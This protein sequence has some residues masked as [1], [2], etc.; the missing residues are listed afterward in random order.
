MAQPL[1]ARPRGLLLS[2]HVVDEL[3]VVHQLAQ[4]GDGGEQP[5]GPPRHDGLQLLAGQEVLVQLLLQGRQLDTHH[6]H[7]RREHREG[8]GRQ[9][10]QSRNRWLMGQTRGIPLA[11][12]S[13]KGTHLQRLGR[14]VL[15]EQSVGPP[16]DEG[17]DDGAQ[18][19]AGVLPF[20][21]LAVGGRRLAALQD[22][23]LEVAP[24]VTGGDGRQ[25]EAALVIRSYTAE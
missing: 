18:L 1:T 20:G 7:P 12:C 22:W 15:A 17:V 10:T 14:Q 24:A 8:R 9:W 13:F 25:G 6:L 16:Q 23:A 21:L 19:A 2:H 4:G 11:K 3:G 5:T